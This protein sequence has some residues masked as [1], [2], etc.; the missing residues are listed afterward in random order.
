MTDMTLDDETKDALTWFILILVTFTL[1]HLSA[2]YIFIKVFLWVKHSNKIIRA[3]Q[4][5]YFSILGFQKLLMFISLLCLCMLSTFLVH[6]TKLYSIE[7][8]S[9]PPPVMV[10]SAVLAAFL[11]VFFIWN[12]PDIRS[13][14]KRRLRGKI[15]SLFPNLSLRSE[16]KSRRIMPKT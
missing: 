7:H 13:F 9:S 15:E 10:L 3:E 16:K 8:S 12:K 11:S 4:S 6:E 5:Q 1:I 2:T 14:V